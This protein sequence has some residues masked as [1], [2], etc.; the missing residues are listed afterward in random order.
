M[1]KTVGRLTDFCMVEVVAANGPEMRYV[2]QALIRHQRLWTSA[3][4]D[5]SPSLVFG[6]KIRGWCR[7]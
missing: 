7:D 6:G 2:R 1:H 5:D 4:R 3:L